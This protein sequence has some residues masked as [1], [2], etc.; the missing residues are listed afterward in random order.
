MSDVCAVTHGITLL[1]GPFTQ[2][3]A[4]C[5]AVRKYCQK[6]YFGIVGEY[7]NKLYA[8]DTAFNVL[9]GQADAIVQ[10]LRNPQDTVRA[11]FWLPRY[12]QLFSKLQQVNSDLFTIHEKRVSIVL[13]QPEVPF[14]HN[15]TVNSFSHLSAEE[16][17]LKNLTKRKSFWLCWEQD[18]V[19]PGL[20]PILSC[21]YHCL[22]G[23]PAASPLSMHQRHNTALLCNFSLILDTCD[24]KLSIFKM[25]PW[26]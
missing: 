2:R 11:S 15:S 7:K 13:A 9:W 10:M 17:G 20:V 22:A 8:M 1:S 26:A 14:T 19:D 18:F 21:W 16:L 23:L 25:R 5:W 4:F 6:Y 24:H 3:L 12:L